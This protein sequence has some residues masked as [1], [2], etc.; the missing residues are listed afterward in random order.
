MRIVAVLV[1]AILVAAALVSGPLSPA[2]AQITNAPAQTTKVAIKAETFAKGL[3]HPWGMAFLPDG[4]L[5]VTERPGR[6]RLVGKDGR[7]SAPLKGVPGSAGLRPRRA[8]RCGARP[9]LR[10]V[11]PDLLRLFGAARRRQQRHQ[12]GTR[13]AGARAGRRPSRRSQG[14][15]PPGALH[16]RRPA[17]RLA[18][19]VRPRRQSVRD[20]GRAIP[21]RQGAGCRQSLRQGGAHPPGRL[22][23]AGQPVR[24][25]GR[26]PARD[27][28][29][30]TPQSTV[31]RR[32]PSNG[33]AVDRGTRCPR[34]R[35]GEHSRRRARTTAGR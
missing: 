1:V 27:L 33:Q 7:L 25:H 28:E 19:R 14:D 22:G 10:L 5:L 6:V 30:R 29:L 23:A 11:A 2:T 15:F 3:V 13:Q 35:R 9:R 21:A 26:R 8:A 34:W 17:L 20:A 4:R 32:P 18:P 16:L 31:G 12:R 24:V